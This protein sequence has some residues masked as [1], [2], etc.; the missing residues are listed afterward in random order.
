MDTHRTATHEHGRLLYQKPGAAGLLQVR[1]QASQCSLYI[2]DIEQSRIDTQRHDTLVLP[3]QRALLACLMFVPGPRKVLLGGLGGGALARFIHRIEPEVMGDAVEIDPQIAA[4]CRRYFDFPARN[5]QIHVGDIRHWQGRDADL[6]II[7][8][9]EADAT[10]S[11]LLSEGC[12]QGLQQGLSPHGVLV[13]DL[14]VDSVQ[15]LSAV[16]QRLRQQFQRRTLCLTVPGHKNII[17]MAFNDVPLHI[18]LPA[19]RSRCA[20]LAAHWHIDFDAL[21]SR[22]QQDNPPDNGFF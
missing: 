18:G 22:L 7:D 21:L 12:L 4:L 17:V 9:A 8:I 16:L 5:W 3:V 6:A 2:D 13:L 14:L 11:W 19:L 15:Q 10:P 1:Q 20:Q